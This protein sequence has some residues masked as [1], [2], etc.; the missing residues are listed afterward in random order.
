MDLDVITH[1]NN[2]TGIKK[3]CVF[4]RKRLKSNFRTIPPKF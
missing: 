3:E 4:E 2:Y 1:V